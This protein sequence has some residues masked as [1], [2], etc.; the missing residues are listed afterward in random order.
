MGDA[1]I[2]IWRGKNETW[3]NSIAVLP[4]ENVGG[5][6]NMEYLSDGITEGLINSLTYLP[7]VRVLARSTMFRFKVFRMKRNVRVF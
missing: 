5:D 6:P 7:G 3:K 1:D 2:Y 4:F